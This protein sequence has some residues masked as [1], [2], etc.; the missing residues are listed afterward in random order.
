MLL[1]FLFLYRFY[2]CS[3][4]NFGDAVQGW[5]ST[6]SIILFIGGLQLLA[7]GIIGNYIAK[8]FLETKKRP[9]YIVKEK[10]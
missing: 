10:G 4:F 3:P 8:I 7:L 9:I 5:A 1:S 6:I 2:Y